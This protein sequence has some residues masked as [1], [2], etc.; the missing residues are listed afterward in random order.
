MLESDLDA[1]P[2]FAEPLPAAATAPQIDSSNAVETPGLEHILHNASNDLH[3][4]MKGYKQ[5]CDRMRELCKILRRREAHERLIERCY[6]TRGPLGEAMAADLKGFDAHV[7]S[8]RW[9]TVAHAAEMIHK[10]RASLQRGWNLAMYNPTWNA[11][12]EAR[13]TS[14]SHCVNLSIVDQAVADPAFWAY[15]EMLQ[16]LARAVSRLL[17]W[18]D[19]CT[20]HWELLQAVYEQKIELPVKARTCWKTCVLRGRRLP[21][22]ATGDLFD[23]VR[24]LFDKAA[25]R[26]ARSFSPL[27]E[28]E[29]R[30]TIIL[31]FE[32]GRSHISFT[33]CVKLSHWLSPPWCVYGLAHPCAAKAAVAW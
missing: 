31:D 32:R 8:E 11:Q 18:C 33:L 23:E 17:S 13:E 14:D 19:S 10:I 9:G 4:A 21:E 30:T 2:D 16:T 28:D 24:K 20:C 15:V 26:L 3:R 27:L 5:C 25:V 6:M 22:L 12:D 7:H 29:E 1:E